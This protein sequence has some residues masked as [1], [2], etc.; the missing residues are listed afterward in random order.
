MIEGFS[1]DEAARMRDELMLNRDAGK[2][3]RCGTP[4]SVLSGAYRG[5][6]LDMV[7]CAVC[8]K[9]VLIYLP[10]GQDGP[11]VHGAPVTG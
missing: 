2:C 11:A 6:E 4:L 1:L 3:P 5:E 10:A 8:G 9:S 7:E